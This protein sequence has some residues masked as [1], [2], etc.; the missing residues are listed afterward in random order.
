MTFRPRP[1]DPDRPVRQTLAQQAATIRNFRIFQLRG[2]HA[3]VGLLTGKRRDRAKALV[4]QELKSMGALSM[5]E[6]AAE[7]IRK[8]GKR[9]RTAA[10]DPSTCADC[11]EP[12]LECDCIPF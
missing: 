1:Y 8:L 10:P 4:D 6:H 11:G 7:R 12:A 9:L 5:A 3:Q 2:L